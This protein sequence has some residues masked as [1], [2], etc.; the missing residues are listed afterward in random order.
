MQPRSAAGVTQHA[1][2]PAVVAFEREKFSS[3]E[4]SQQ[5][6]E[7]SSSTRTGPE[8]YN[9]ILA[10]E[11]KLELP[12]IGQGSHGVVRNRR[13]GGINCWVEGFNRPCKL[14]CKLRVI[15]GVTY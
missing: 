9:F 11:L 10:E 5:I 13:G 6:T 1:A 4:G 14:G 12:P 3:R 7:T 15:R 8:R 2:A